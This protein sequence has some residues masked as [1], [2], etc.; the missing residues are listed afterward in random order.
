VPG[1]FGRSTAPSVRLSSVAFS[2]FGDAHSPDDVTVGR[3][4]PSPYF[5]GREWR[6]WW[7]RDA[8]WAS[9]NVELVMMYRCL[10]CGSVPGPPEWQFR[11]SRPRRQPVSWWRTLVV[12]W[13]PPMRGAPP[14][15]PPNARVRVATSWAQLAA[16]SLPRAADCV[17]GFAD[18]CLSQPVEQAYRHPELRVHRR[19][20]CFVHRSRDVG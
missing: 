5:S 3:T 19:K 11:A 7:P 14:H 6:F 1:C 18:D 8:P 4:W 15:L 16:H 20:P 2:T 12:P 9:S 10:S 17:T 13:M